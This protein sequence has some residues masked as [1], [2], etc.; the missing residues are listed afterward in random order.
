MEGLIWLLAFQN[1]SFLLED[2]TVEYSWTNISGISAKNIF[3]PRSLYYFIPRGFAENNKFIQTVTLDCDI[4]ARAFKGCSSLTTVIL[5]DTTFHSV[6]SD[7]FA[8]CPNLSKIIVPAR[9]F[10]QYKTSSKWKLY[11]DLICTE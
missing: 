9:F 1:T 7:S 2:L 6:R 11:R 10:E 3:I 8:D 4:E 5:E